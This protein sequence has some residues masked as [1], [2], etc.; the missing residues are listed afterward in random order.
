MH[1]V[2]SGNIT[3]ESGKT[4]RDYITDY[5]TTALK[6]VPIEEFPDRTQESYQAGALDNG[7]PAPAEVDNS[8]PEPQQPQA[9][10]PTTVPEQPVGPGRAVSTPAGA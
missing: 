7:T 9:P 4:C 5:M 3:L 1:D 8:T 2:Q 10:E 6:D